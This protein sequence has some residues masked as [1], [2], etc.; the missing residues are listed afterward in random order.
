LAH[1]PRSIE[2]IPVRPPWFHCADLR[3]GVVEL[4]DAESHHAL[5]SLRLETGAPLV[6]FD[7]AGCVADAT[8]EPNRA[9][10]GARRSRGWRG[11]SRVARVTQIRFVPPPERTLTLI[12]AGCKGDRLSFLIEKCTELGVSRIVLARFERSIVHTGERH[13]EKLLRTALEACKQCRRAWIPEITAGS[14]LP[15]AVAAARTLTRRIAAQRSGPESGAT[16]SVPDPACPPV[17]IVCHPAPDVPPLGEWLHTA[18]PP[19][20]VAV[21]GPEG[22]LSPGEVES[23]RSRRAEFLRL[24]EHILRV[25]TAAIAVAAA[26]AAGGTRAGPA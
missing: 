14:R 11:A 23:L 3:A 12:V 20:L 25:E 10:L 6:L 17:L 13:A 19:R 1:V 16:S 26:W 22:G 9:A 4:D 5:A 15:D 2:N 7:G 18:R 8:L 24:A 21:I